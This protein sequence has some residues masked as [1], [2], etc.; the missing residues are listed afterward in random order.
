MTKFVLN[1][2]GDEQETAHA[3]RTRSWAWLR[4]SGLV[5]LGLT[6]AGVAYQQWG[7]ARDARRFPA[8][9]E[10]VSVGDH[11]LHIWC[12]G[13]GQPIVMM[14][15]GDGTPSVTLY[16]AQTKIARFT[17][18]CSYDRAGLGWS[19]PQTRAM[20]LGDKVDDLDRLVTAK[21]SGPLVLVPESGGNL[22]ALGYAARAPGR[23]AGA[24]F[25]DASEPDLWFRGTPSVLP[26]LRQQNLFWQV[27]WRLG[28]TRAVLPFAVP[29]WVDQLSPKLR[30]Q[31]DAVWSKPMPSYARDAIDT[32]EQ[33]KVEDRPTARAGLLG[34]RPIAVIRH[35]VSGG[36]EIPAEF[37]KEWP[38]AQAKLAKLSSN[39]RSIVATDNHHPIAEE[40][41]QLVADVVRQ[42][43]FTIRNRAPLARQAGE[44]RCCHSR[45]GGT[46]VSGVL[47]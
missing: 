45:S 3:S 36:P 39:S 13:T 21:A 47:D 41:P 32:W 24:V 43:I 20:S 44:R 31:F 30:G 11:R 15:S 7:E 37:E 18:V 22:I 6:L 9:G 33:T 38:A 46:D 35:G 17:R 25:V 40:N 26:S 27:G 8:P 10:L 29:A 14:I 12:V 42:V 2:F 19:D 23:V 1:T 4:R 5:L 34:D 28:V 16:A